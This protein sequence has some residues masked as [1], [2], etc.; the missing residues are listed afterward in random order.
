MSQPGFFS[1]RWQSPGQIGGTEDIAVVFKVPGAIDLSVLPDLIESVCAGPIVPSAIVML[2]LGDDGLPRALQTSPVKSALSRFTGRMPL[3]VF[4]ISL[5]PFS[6]NLS[7][8]VE[9]PTNLQGKL[10]QM[11]VN[12]TAWVQAGLS[13]IFD[14]NLVVVSAPSGY[15]FLKP[16]NERS[17]FFIRAELALSNSAAVNFVAF[18]VFLR[19]V[20]DFGQV[21][22]ELRILLVDTMN[23]APIAFALREMLLSAGVRVAPQIESFHSYGGIDQVASP[24]PDTSL[25]IV[26]ASSSMNLHRKWTREKA[27]ASRDIITLLTFEDAKDVE[28]ALYGLP[29]SAR[30]APSSPSSTYDIRI[31]GEYFFP[32]MEPPRKVL[33]T[34][35]HHGCPEQAQEI[36]RLRDCK[37]FGAF[38]S[39]DGF[40]TRKGL[41]I[42]ANALLAVEE[43][44]NWINLKVPQLLRAGTKWVIYQ[45]DSASARL[46][47]HVAHIALVM[48]CKEVRLCNAIE[49]YS[50]K[51]DSVAPIVCVAAVVGRGNAL[52]NLSRDLRNS[53]FG[54]RLFLIGMQVSDS[55]R[56]LDAFDRNLKYSSHKSPIEVQRKSAFLSSDTLVESFQKE[57]SLYKGRHILLERKRNLQVGLGPTEVFL[58][59]GAELD[60]VLVLNIDFAFWGNKY[61]PSAYQAQV[62]AT[63]AN[64]LQNARTAKLTSHTQQLRSPLLMHV[65]LDPEN[66]A[67]FNEGII[68]AALLR[69]AL[70]S[71]LDYRGDIQASAY[72]AAFLK[73]IALNYDHSQVATLEFLSAIATKRLQLNANDT[74]I[75][76]DAFLLASKSKATPMAMAVRMFLEELTLPNANREA[77]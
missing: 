24:L 6:L 5:A 17:T 52:L 63:I 36:Y 22:Q 58:P 77:F 44:Q 29:I 16:S 71:E 26:S 39:T 60:E 25:C 64:T 11:F 31:T 21:P 32:V 59:S 55:M 51:I 42:D 40:E 68:Q 41:F 28:H 61:T 57:L 50:T 48:G 30:P 33:L 7:M 20:R 70:P 4:T 18:A 74:L 65:A 67:R 12:P 27:L 69:S 38:K 47:Q 34:T 76:K 73:R 43:F 66:F 1:F 9:A 37:V 15:A 62:L 13:A 3:L 2:Q 10:C 45:N 75:V 56:K 35:T 53:H 46:A 23:V 14:P 49:V 8:E 19:I 54:A 72:L